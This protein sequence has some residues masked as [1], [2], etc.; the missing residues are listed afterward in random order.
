MPN[1][2]QFE[3]IAPQ[4]GF[5]MA[6][7]SSLP[8]ASRLRR[9]ASGRKA[10]PA[11]SGVKTRSAGLLPFRPI[12]RQEPAPRAAQPLSPDGHSAP[13]RSRAVVYSTLISFGSRRSFPP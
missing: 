9:R 1:R 10:A 3:E 8:S 4:I 13:L 12:E 6:P 11:T 7:D 5:V 2:D